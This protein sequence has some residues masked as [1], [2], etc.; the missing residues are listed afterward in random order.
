ML[1]LQAGSEEEVDHSVSQ[2]SADG[3]RDGIG[4]TGGGGGLGG[5]ICIG[6]FLWLVQ[7]VAAR[8]TLLAKVSGDATCHEEGVEVITHANILAIGLELEKGDAVIM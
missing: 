8:G 4:C 5:N 3:A 2:G 1:S 7:V 6:C